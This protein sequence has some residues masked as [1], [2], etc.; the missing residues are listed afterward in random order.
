MPAQ[1]AL[2]PELLP[3]G[4]EPHPMTLADFV[5]AL[6]VAMARYERW[7]RHLSAEINRVFI[8]LGAAAQDAPSTEDSAAWT[9]ASLLIVPLVATGLISSYDYDGDGS[10]SFDEIAGELAGTGRLM[11]GVEDQA[12]A[13]GRVREMLGQAQESRGQLRSLLEILR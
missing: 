7:C 13:R 6:G 12:G 10:L 11:F 2:F 1:L 8:H 3:Q 9:G 4:P 5:I